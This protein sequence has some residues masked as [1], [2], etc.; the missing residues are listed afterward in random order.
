MGN[1]KFNNVYIKN[2][3][4]I[5]GPKEKDSKIS[6]VNLKFD[7]LYFGK[8]TFEDAEIKM[9]EVSIQNLLNNERLSENKIDYVFATDLINQLGVSSQTMS[10]FNIPFVG[11]YAACAGFPLQILLCSNL[12]ESKNAKNII[13]LAS[14]HN[15]TAERQFR[16]PTEYG[17]PKKGTATCTLTACVSMLLTN[18]KTNIKVSGG[19][20]GKVVNLGI[21]D[22]N[23]MGAVMAPACADTIYTYLQNAHETVKDYDLILT[24]DLGK[25]GL[26]ILKEYYEKVYNERLNKIMDAG[27]EIFLETSQYSGGS[28]PVCLPLV[29]LTKILKNK[30]YKKILIV[31]SGS[32]H[33]PTLVNQ[34]KEIPAISHLV[35]IEVLL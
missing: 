35:K 19:L 10:N 5:A 29:F 3:Y 20:I 14:S 18:E 26:N 17:C 1:L 16:Y 24:G 4:T 15:L 11:V 6:N 30:K 9:Q 31:G 28:G 12:I 22:V 27:D 25:V 2:F 8:Q 33:N 34:G 13:T 23:N 7:D 32:L 21:N